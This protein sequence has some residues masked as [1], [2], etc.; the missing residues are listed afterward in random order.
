MRPAE[1]GPTKTILPKSLFAPTD[2]R[3]DGSWLLANERWLWK[4]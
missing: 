2:L 3:N 1:S 4:L